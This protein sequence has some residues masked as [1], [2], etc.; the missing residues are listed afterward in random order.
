MILTCVLGLRIGETVALKWGDIDW[1]SMQIRIRRHELYYG[2]PSD[3]FRSTGSQKYRIEERTKGKRGSIGYRDVSLVETAVNLLDNLKA[4]YNE[5]EI[6]S[7]WIF[8]ENGKRIITTLWKKP[9]KPIAD[10]LVFHFGAHTK[11]EQPT[12]P[13]FTILGLTGIQ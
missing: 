2:E 4:Y 3:D 6:D 13:C 12:F 7:E 1:R 9:L 5:N 8:V 11:Q 10:A